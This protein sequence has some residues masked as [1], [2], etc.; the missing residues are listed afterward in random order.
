MSFATIP[1]IAISRWK[2]QSTK[3]HYWDL[4]DLL[5]RWRR[6]RQNPEFARLVWQ[7]QLDF[8]LRRVQPV[9][10]ECS[11][12]AQA[13]ASWLIR[14]WESTP[15]DGVSMGYFPCD[16]LDRSPN[17]NGWRPSYPETTGYIISSL[18]DYANRYNDAAMFEKA[19]SMALWETTVQMESGAV[20]GGVVTSADK[21]HPAIFNTGMVLHGYTAI[22]KTTPNN[23]I[24]HHARR[25]AD[26]LL[27]DLKEDDHFYTH[28]PFV[29]NHRI[30]TYN[31]L[32]AWSLYR[33]GEQMQEKKYQQ[34]ALRTATAS[35][36]L[37][38]PNGW[39]PHNCL[40]REEAPLTHTIGYT[41]QGILETGVASGHEPLINSARR[42][43]LP[44]LNA[45]S[46]TGFLPGRFHA[47]WSPA[48]FSSCLT[49]SAQLA[50]VCFRLFQVLGD[51]QF[52]EA[53]NRLLN[54]L[55]GLQ[56]IQTPQTPMHGGLPGSFPIFTGEYMTAGYPNWATKYLL[57]ALLLQEKFS[58]N[59]RQ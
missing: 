27:A 49:G 22:L 15:D 20:Q 31:C 3:E 51:P 19:L 21:Q 40:T 33:F 44:I 37:Q 47:D 43:L 9:T 57:D 6:L 14:A 41:L 34:A 48:S 13:A 36:R 52:L 39:F 25:A 7:N 29:T 10:G 17:R 12:R 1:G 32:C 58:L 18:I 26:F 54:Y 23:T 59:T 38:H 46:P 8:L 24:E 28:G 16:P 2:S 4:R 5:T 35:M 50:I 11:L 53:G 30:K 56:L 55:K 45:I 42:G